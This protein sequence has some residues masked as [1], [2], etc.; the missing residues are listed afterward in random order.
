MSADM[1]ITGFIPSRFLKCLKHLPI[2]LSITSVL[3]DDL[4]IE[5][6]LPSHQN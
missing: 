2:D 1:L 3:G 6:T 5:A 4:T